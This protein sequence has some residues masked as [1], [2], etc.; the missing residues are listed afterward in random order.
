[1]RTCVLAGGVGSARLLTGLVGVADPGG[2]TVVVNTGDDMVIRGLHVSPD[3]D[4]VLYHLAGVS[5]LERGWGVADESFVADARYAGLVG[6]LDLDTE[7]H[8]WFA[9]GDRDLATHM[10]RTALLTSGRTLTQATD[11]LRT[12]MGIGPV[13]LPMSDA[14]APTIVHTTE[15][16]RLDFQTYFVRRRHADKLAR[17]E[18]LTGD[19]APAPGVLAAIED[20]DVVLIPPSNPVLSVAPIL[21][22]PGVRERI[23]AARTIAVSPIV[24]GEAVKGPAAAIMRSMF[25][26]ASATTVA[27]AYRG[28]VDVFVLDAVDASRSE[29]IAALG[30]QPVVADTMM[31]GPEAAARLCEEIM[32][33]V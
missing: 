19:A 18:Y 4:T 16:E 21:E 6:K 14:P 8:E 2:I 7:L 11:A 15:G 24:G 26:E 10:L 12:A 3:I 9:L 32:A 29:A 22:L 1:M 25:G 33:H 17:V 28:L 27:G 5:D 30:M 31:T 20:A 23:A 13:V